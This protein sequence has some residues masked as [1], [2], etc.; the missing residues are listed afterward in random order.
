MLSALLVGYEV[1]Q[2][3]E[4]CEKRLL[5]AFGMMEALHHEQLPIDGVVGLIQHGARHWHSVW[6]KNSCGLA[7]VV[8]QQSAKPLVTLQWPCTYRVLAD[9]RKEQNIVFALM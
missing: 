1:V 4:P 9:R 8:L 2:M 5:A 6:P 7:L 3:G